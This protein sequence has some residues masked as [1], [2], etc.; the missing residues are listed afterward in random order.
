[1]SGVRHAGWQRPVLIGLGL[2]LAV[3][4]LFALSYDA[5]DFHV[6]ALGGRA[7]QHDQQLYEF[8]WGQHGF[9]YPPFAAA[10][11]VPFTAVP[12]ALARLLWDAASVAALALA[13]RATARLAGRRPDP[14][15]LAALTA[16]GLLLEP[17][18]HTLFLGQIN[19]LLLAAVLVDV[20]RIARGRTAG[21]GIGVAA[22]VKLTPAIFILLLVLAGRRRSAALA[23][24]TAAAATAIGALVAPHA[25]WQY[26]TGYF[27]DLH[28]VGSATYASNQSIHGALARAFGAGSAW[29]VV[30]ALSVGV[31][32]LVTA[33]RLARRADWLAAAAVT[34]VTGLLVSPISWS[35][36]WVWVIP[37]L[38]VLAR[39]GTRSRLAAAGGY[40]LFVLAP[41]W[42]PAPARGLDGVATLE[43]NAY[44]LAGLA[45]V[46]YAARAGARSR[47]RT[48]RLPAPVPVPV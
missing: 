30:L 34:G 8:H 7:V 45:F 11:F 37:A 35:H 18:W 46:V 2:Q 16:A 40:A 27:A 26:W 4:G 28:R 36:H 19:L 44:A 24:A 17:V 20:E 9:T 3:I 38:A 6:Y 12:L 29:E 14:L 15:E 23:A 10:A 41:I 48:R 22:A 21:V 39:E 42:W 13:T 31:V 43:S 47:A 1:M 25:S 32:G 5:Y 33:A